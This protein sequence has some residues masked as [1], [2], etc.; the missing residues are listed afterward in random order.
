MVPAKETAEEQLLRMIEGPGGPKPASPRAPRPHLSFDRFNQ[1]LKDRTGSLWRWMRPQDAR[2]SS[3][4]LLW[5][6]RLMERVFWLVLVGLTLY[7]VVTI[8][9]LQPKLPRMARPLS[10]SQAAAPVTAPPE[11]GNLKSLAE[12]RDTLMTRNPFGVAAQK[13]GNALGGGEQVRHRLAEMARVLSVVGIN[14]GRVPEA[15]I[16][17]TEAKRTF[18]VKVGEQV[19][20][21]TVKSIDQNG[22]TVSYE[23]EETV[24]Q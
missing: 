22:V 19:N 2:E 1:Q 5:R 6:L 12:Y 7:L 23:G 8:W 15:L 14:R 3:D 10:S 17:D 16:E 18:V 4:L 21:L 11:E 13:I 24:L 20:Q 9:V